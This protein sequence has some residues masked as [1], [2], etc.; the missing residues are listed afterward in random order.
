LFRM[1][2]CSMAVRDN[3]MVAGGFRGE[4]VCKVGV[5]NFQSLFVL[6]TLAHVICI[7]TV[8]WSTWSGFLYKCYWW[9]W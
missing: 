5:H 7:W 3:L 2:I 8:R 6:C 4:L 1:Q 9:W